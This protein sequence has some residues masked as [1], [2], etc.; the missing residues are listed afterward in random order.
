MTNA[1]IQASIEAILADKTKTP[2]YSLLGLSSIDYQIEAERMVR[3]AIAK[4]E[5]LAEVTA[6]EFGDGLEVLWQP[7][8]TE[9]RSETYPDYSALPPQEAADK[10]VEYALAQYLGTYNPSG[11]ID[12]ITPSV[13]SD[14]RL[15]VVTVFSDS[16]GYQVE[17]VS[18]AAIEKILRYDNISQYD[19]LWSY[20]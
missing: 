14:A 9:V 17:I 8:T 20:K 4:Y 11:V 13:E 7:V 1:D 5:P 6:V 15:R 12:E 10:L 3:S 18:S 2:L 19:G 16:D